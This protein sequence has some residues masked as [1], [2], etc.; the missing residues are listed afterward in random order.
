[1]ASDT[2][3]TGYECGVFNGRVTPGGT[4]AIVGCGPVGL[5]SLLTA[6]LY[7][8]GL[9]VAVDVD[10]SRLEI[11]RKIGATATVRNTLGPDSVKELLDLTGS[12]GFDTVIEAVGLPEAFELCQS[13]LAPGGVIANMGVHGVPAPLHLEKL[14]D[15]NISMCMISTRL[16]ALLTIFTAITTRLVDTRSTPM[17]LSLVAS[18]KIDLSVLVTHEIEFLN[19]MEAY[20]VF[21]AASANKALKV[22]LTFN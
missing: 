13:I 5:A 19:G 10:P 16:V 7:S 12:E 11:A 20:R 22:I 21:G 15:R 8:P 2:L 3:P 17:L 1:M 14:W 9:I 4:V 6:H 18:G